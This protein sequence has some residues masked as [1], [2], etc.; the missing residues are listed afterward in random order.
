MDCVSECVTKY[1]STLPNEAVAVVGTLFTGVFAYLLVYKAR[2]VVFSA[3]WLGSMWLL[4]RR[5][6]VPTDVTQ[7]VRAWW[8][9]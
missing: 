1:T 3:V 2:I 5:E 6:D 4:R 8:F 7:F 9:R